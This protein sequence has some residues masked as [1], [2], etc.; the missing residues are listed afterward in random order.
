GVPLALIT[1]YPL[2]ITHLSEPR[3]PA[4]KGRDLIDLYDCTDYFAKLEVRNMKLELLPQTTLFNL[5]FD[6]L[7]IDLN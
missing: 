6:S 7:I 4:N 5:Y 2:P 3:F 1:D